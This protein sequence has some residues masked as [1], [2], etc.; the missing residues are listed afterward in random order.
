MINLFKEK[1]NSILV[2]AAAVLASC[3]LGFINGFPLIYPDT[4]TYIGS[5]FTNDVPYDRPIF[6]GWFLRHISLSE[7]LWLPIL[8]Q[9]L[10][11]CFLLYLTVGMFLSGNTKR[12]VFIISVFIV[13]FFTC[14]TYNVSFLMPD[15]FAPLLFLSL[16]NLWFNTK[17]KTVTRVVVAIIFLFS[18][19]VHLSNVMIIGILLAAVLVLFI[20]RKIKKKPFPIPRPNFFIPYY[21]TLSVLIVVPVVNGIVSDSYGFTGGSHVFMVN[22]LHETGVLDEYLK[23]RCSTESYKICQY[24]DSMTWDF[25]WDSKSPLYKTGGWKANKEEYNKILLDVYTTPKYFLKMGVKSIEYTLVQFFTFTTPSGEP[26]GMQSS[27][28]DRVNKYFKDYNMTFLRSKQNAKSLFPFLPQQSELFLVFSSM[29]CL[30]ICL[31][32]TTNKLA[33]W[34]PTLNPLIK[35]LFLFTFIN[36]FICS[37]LAVIDSRFQSRIVWLFPFLLCVIVLGRLI[38]KFEKLIH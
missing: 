23:D 38:P 20:Y 29:I 6:Y 16:F 2:F 19:M 18:L 12:I 17:L 32:L 1:K 27:P 4:G 37:N 14:Y 24:K 26:F 15:I 33:T 5:G 3:Y 22:H 35:L 30:L 9:S 8:A 11:S 25:L 21:L 34:Y 28:G 7:T 13:S 31:F 36:C 10:L